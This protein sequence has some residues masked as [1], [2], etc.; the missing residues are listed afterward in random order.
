MG[1][2]AARIC[3]APTRPAC[4]GLTL[5]DGGLPPFT[6]HFYVDGPMRV[7]DVDFGGSDWRTILVGGLGKGGK[8]F[9]ALDVT[10]PVASA[11]TEADIIAAQKVLWE[12]T[13]ADMGYSYGKPLMV[14]TQRARLGRDPDV[15]L[16]QP[17]AATARCTSSTRG[18]ARC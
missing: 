3:T 15:G 2:R 9:Y 13:H 10:T 17:V 16:Q 7:A 14:K 8:S 4:G 1:V 5:Q 6:H 11:N 18:R 12:F